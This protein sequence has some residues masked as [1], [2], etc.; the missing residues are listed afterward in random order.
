MAGAVDFYVHSGCGDPGGLGGVPLAVEEGGQLVGCRVGLDGAEFLRVP[1]VEQ[2]Q[3]LGEHGAVLAD[4]HLL[5]KEAEGLQLGVVPAGELFRRVKDNGLA[6][7]VVGS[8]VI[9][10][11]FV[12]DAPA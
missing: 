3:H 1:L 8:R 2:V 7:A 10:P 11:V 6:H 9:Q 4:R 5:P 12:P